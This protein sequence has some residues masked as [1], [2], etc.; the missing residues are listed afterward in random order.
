MYKIQEQQPVVG[1]GSARSAILESAEQLFAEQG[2]NAVS[3]S[4]IAL[5]A[6]ASKANVFHHF[7]SKQNLYMAVLKLATDRAGGEV[8]RQV[9]AG[10]G[11]VV[12]RLSLFMANYLQVLISYP[13][14]SRLVMR[15]LMEKGERDGAI[16]ARELF[17]KNFVR[18]V[19][20]IREGQCSGVLRKD[21]DA[22]LLTVLMVGIHVFFFH[23]RSVIRHLPGV[24]FAADA[25]GFSHDALDLLLRGALTQ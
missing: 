19:G 2:F 5:A 10:Q 18:I 14:T 13:R 7:G 24:E 17:T 4:E 16:L 12:E 1:D 15:E 9:V 20:L 21:L 25:E 3:I 6:R 8:G 22:E 23:T 11:G